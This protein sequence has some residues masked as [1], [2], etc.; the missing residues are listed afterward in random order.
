MFD[1]GAR[2]GN[3]LSDAERALFLAWQEKARS[4]YANSHIAFDVHF[5]E[6]AFLRT[7]GYSEIPERFLLR[8]TI[9]VF[10]TEKLGYDIDRERT[11]GCSIGP[12]PRWQKIPAHPFFKTFLGLA[13]AKETTLPHE[14]S[15]HFTLDTVHNPSS[16][17]NVWADLRND[18]LLWRQRHGAHIKEFRA[19]A[20]SEWAR[21]TSSA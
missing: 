21:P 20:K 11:G 18:Y 1:A 8:P 7:Q 12:H 9:N 19:C 6:G 2:N 3:G 15:H 17:R 14:Y 5:T 4:Q 13:D 10:V 16:A